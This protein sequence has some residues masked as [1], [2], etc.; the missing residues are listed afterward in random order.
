MFAFPQD[1][2][3]LLTWN[4]L[5]GA[6]SILFQF[7][8]SSNLQYHVSYEKLSS[9]IIYTCKSWNIRKHTLFHKALYFF[10][11]VTSASPSYSLIFLIFPLYPHIFIYFL[12]TATIE[13]ILSLQS[14]STQFSHHSDLFLWLL[15]ILH[16]KNLQDY[17]FDHR[18]AEW[19]SG[20][21]L[22]GKWTLVIILTYC[23]TRA[24]NMSYLSWS[25]ASF[26][27]LVQG[28]YSLQFYMDNYTSNCECSIP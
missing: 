3:N 11:A 27:A 8:E 4:E 21:L 9:S 13:A 26:Q 10:L 25:K 14:L 18:H 15:Q 12:C 28:C 24:E 16:F 20:E 22:Q 17:L 19:W 5:P 6:S 2:Q 7:H 23:S 1:H